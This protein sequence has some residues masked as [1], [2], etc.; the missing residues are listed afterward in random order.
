MKKSKH[1]PNIWRKEELAYMCYWYD[2]LGLSEVALNL[3]RSKVSV[4]RMLSRITE[5]GLFE[6]YRERWLQGDYE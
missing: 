4:E 1:P 3:G 5:R 2:D 6:Y